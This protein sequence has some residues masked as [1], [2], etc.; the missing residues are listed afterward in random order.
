MINVSKK[1]L[2]SVI[3]LEIHLELKTKSKIFC[4]CSNNSVEKIPNKNICPI[5]LGHPGVLPVLN[6]EAVIKILKLAL[7]IKGEINFCSSFDRKNYF[8]PDLPK[9]YQISQ[10]YRPFVRGGFLK[11]GKEKILF[12]NIH[13][14]EDTA[15][16]LHSLSNKET[17]LDFNR[18][19]IPL[20]EITTLP[21][22]N[23][24]RE[25]KLFLKELQLLV[26]YL[27]ISEANMEKGQMRCD[28][29]IS[30]RQKGEKKLFPKTEI[31]NLNSFRSVEMAL[32][33]EI[34][35]QTKLWQRGIP[36]DFSSTR[37]WD[38]K[39]KR[40]FIEREKEELKDYR[41]FPEPDLLIY[42]VN[43][44][45][46]N[47]KLD[48]L[49]RKKIERFIEDYDFTLEEAEIL[50][51]NKKIADFTEEV[52]LKLKDNL[53][54]LAEIEG[55]EEERW[56][57]YK[58]KLAHL[59]ANWIINKFLPFYKQNKILVNSE[60]IPITSDNF[61]RFIIL[62]YENK[63]SSALRTEILK[64]MILKGEDVDN[65]IKEYSKEDIRESNDLEQIIKETL[66]EK[67]ELVSLYKKG[68]INV[69]H[70]FVGEIMKKTKGR[71]EPE[72]IRKILEKKL[73]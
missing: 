44:L 15:K 30:L 58:K 21:V 52:I 32:N 13:L 4:S 61:S 55:D 40:T 65:L 35:R 39:N 56:E 34:L 22:I 42:D 49:P 38:E 19:G 68:K 70:V 20:L 66:E 72:K 26:R 10:Y 37:G 62:V 71:I 31:K 54:S 59:T 25:A 17:F 73:S 67:K 12:D 3:G 36:P 29:N 33:Y 45:I 46:K 14:E 27:E 41:Y 8:Y 6:K 9:A 43:F 48:E 64:Q 2:E 1:E 7:A 47:I 11:I 60:E 50:V 51:E 53:L 63:I 28:A 23:S 16:L 18:A 69:I 57:K 24:A 5:C